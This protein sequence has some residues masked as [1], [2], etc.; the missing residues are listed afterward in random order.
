M[1]TSL[2]GT[3]SITNNYWRPV[4]AILTADTDGNPDTV[5]D[6]TGTPLQLTYPIPDYDSGHSVQGGTGASVLREFFGTDN[7]SFTACSLTLP[8]GSRC[9]DPTPV[10][11][12]YANFSQAA[13]ENGL[14]RILIGIHFRHAVE[15]G[16]QHGQKIGKRAVNLFLRPA[17]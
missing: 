2:P 12:S 6:P 9:S 7:I 15:E 4:T 1:A 8:A 3:Q 11:R 10:L 5:G 16:I 13:D 17:H 14:S